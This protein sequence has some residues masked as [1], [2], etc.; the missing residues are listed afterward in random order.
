MTRF[1][2][3]PLEAFRVF[4][5]AAR[6]LNFTAAAQE[7]GVTQAAVSRRVQGLEAALGAQLFARRG[8]RLALTPE[9]ARLMARTRAALDHLAEAVESFAPAARPLSLAA[10]GSVSHLWLDAALRRFADARPDIPVRVLT[11]DAMGELASE[12][13]DVAILYAAGEHPRWRLTPLLPER[14]APVASAGYAAAHG[15]TARTPAARLATLDLIDY[16][17]FNAHWRTLADWFARSGVKPGA[18]RI[19]YSTYAMTAEA[20]L[21]GEG[22]ALGSLALLTRALADGRLVRV[23]GPVW[24]TGFGY[25]VGLPRDRAASEAAE[26]LA[27]A[28][29][30]AA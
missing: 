6:R 1:D 24:E 21:R 22:V 29:R 16:E 19:L 3:I 13:H 28:L 27:A 14:L 25:H 23:G 8:R 12:A 4:E 10:P 30:A 9:G 7:L 17:P 5:A 26:A 2:R 20:A 11:T 18:P 15:L